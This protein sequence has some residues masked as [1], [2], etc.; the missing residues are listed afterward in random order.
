MDKKRERENI[1]GKKCKL[2]K[3][4]NNKSTFLY[5]NQEK[6]NLRFLSTH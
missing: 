5:L 3:Y 1:Y 4:K 6:P 2:K